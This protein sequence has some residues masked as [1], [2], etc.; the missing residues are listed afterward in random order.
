MSV[1][2]AACRRRRPRVCSLADA[3]AAP[4]QPQAVLYRG[5]VLLCVG[6]ATYIPE[7]AL[8]SMAV[9]FGGSGGMAQR[10]ASD[11]RSEGW[12]FESL[13][14]LAISK[15][16]V[17]VLPLLWC[18]AIMGRALQGP[19]CPGAAPPVAVCNS[20]CG[21]GRAAPRFKQFAFGG[22]ASGL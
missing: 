5:V 10:R 4:L 16:V 3:C 22:A 15:F 19:G 1:A 21:H 8:A 9:P 6:V 20:R 12:E 18:C 11:S 13:P 7:A 14:S 2:N 17:P